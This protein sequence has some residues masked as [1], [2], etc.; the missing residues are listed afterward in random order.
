MLRKTQFIGVDASI[1]NLFAVLFLELFQRNELIG[2]A[3]IPKE[4]SIG[5]CHVIYFLQSD[6]SGKGVLDNRRA[7][8][9]PFQ[10]INQ[11]AFD[12]IE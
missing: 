3:L 1:C 10:Q 5:F 2:I 11:R 9:M 7:N 8:R 12:G 4:T 6:F